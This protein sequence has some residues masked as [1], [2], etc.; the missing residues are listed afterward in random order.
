MSP[1]EDLVRLQRGRRARRSARWARRRRRPHLAAVR[2]RR[3]VGGTR[4]GSPQRG[5]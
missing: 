5:W 1:G 2:A 3:T 4:Q